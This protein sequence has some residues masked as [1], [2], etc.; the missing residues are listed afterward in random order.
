[1]YD[2]SV[3]KKEDYLNKKEI[4]EKVK[5]IKTQHEEIKRKEI[6]EQREFRNYIKVLG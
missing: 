1:M 5:L 6:V 2:M 4:V 3:Q